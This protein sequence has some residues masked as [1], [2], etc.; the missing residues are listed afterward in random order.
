MSKKTFNLITGIV[1]GVSTIAIAVVTFINPSYA[2]AINASIG[3]ASTATIEICNQFVTKQVIRAVKE[4][5]LLLYIPNKSIFVSV[6]FAEEQH[7]KK[8]FFKEKR[9]GNER[10]GTP[11]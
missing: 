6:L 3:I 1:G 8:H 10:L 11:Y 5:R 7:I 4:L 2:V 9:Y